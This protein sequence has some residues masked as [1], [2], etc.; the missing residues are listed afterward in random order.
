MQTETNLEQELA[1]Y[2]KLPPEVSTNMSVRNLVKVLLRIK[3]LFE[4][5]TSAIK[6]LACLLQLKNALRDPRIKTIEVYKFALQWR[7]LLAAFKQEL[8]LFGPKFVYEDIDL[9]EASLKV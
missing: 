3:K 2:R 1:W 6:I 7:Q 5:R 9:F 4:A 8:K